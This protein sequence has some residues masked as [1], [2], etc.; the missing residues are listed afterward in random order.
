[1]SW[2]RSQRKTV[3]SHPTARMSSFGAG[4]NQLPLR[5]AVS[6]LITGASFY[7]THS[8]RRGSEEVLGASSLWRRVLRAFPPLL[9]FTRPL[10]HALPSSPCTQIP[11]NHQNFPLPE[12]CPVLLAP[13]CR[14]HVPFPESLQPLQPQVPGTPCF[15][16]VG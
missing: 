4:G 16:L 3:G 14:D 2:E 8:S 1:M 10:A 5:C 9:F 7:W 6:F 13:A 12:A 11:P 15:I